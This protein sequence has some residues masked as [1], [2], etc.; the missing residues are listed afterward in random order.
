M[1]AEVG[2]LTDQYVAKYTQLLPNLTTPKDIAKEVVKTLKGKLKR[3]FDTQVEFYKAFGAPEV[4]RLRSVF[5]GLQNKPETPDL[6]EQT[7]LDEL[8]DAAE[9][10]NKDRLNTSRRNRQTGGR[11]GRGNG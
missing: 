5:E 11:R 4:Q 1:F 2:V 8:Q 6:G 10:L 3:K 7:D 9:A